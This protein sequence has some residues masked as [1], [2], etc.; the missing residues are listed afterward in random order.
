V[1]LAHGA[2]VGANNLLN[3]PIH[4]H[5]GPD[6]PF[7]ECRDRVRPSDE[8]SDLMTDMVALTEVQMAE[9]TDLQEA[10]CQFMDS[11]YEWDQP[12][13]WWTKCSLYIAIM[14]KILRTWPDPNLINHPV[15]SDVM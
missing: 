13:T 9:L 8:H 5:H 6:G 11:S 15:L 4:P 12:Q 7:Q 10:F 3:H 1:S 2:H 14:D